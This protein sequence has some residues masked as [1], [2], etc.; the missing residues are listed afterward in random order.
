MEKMA[1]TSAVTFT[2]NVLSAK[3]PNESSHHFCRGLFNFFF[4]IKSQPHSWFY[5]VAAVE[6]QVDSRKARLLNP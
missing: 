3:R 1:Q 4:L 2:A 6:S 5:I